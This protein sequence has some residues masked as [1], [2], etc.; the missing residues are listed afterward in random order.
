[1][2]EAR[3]I[4]MPAERSGGFQ[5]A[6]SSAGKS[7]RPVAASG[8][9]PLAASGVLLRCAI[10]PGSAIGRTPPHSSRR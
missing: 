6:N 7:Y 10:V 8:V 3:V 9:L 5:A 2:R 1:M 4:V